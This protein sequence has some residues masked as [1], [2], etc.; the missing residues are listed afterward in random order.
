MKFYFTF[1]FGQVHENGF[2]VIFADNHEKARDE[3]VEKFGLKWAFQYTEKEW[4][5]SEG[6]SQEEEFNLQEIK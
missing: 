4:F 6:I 1:G 3:M 2:Y 5:N